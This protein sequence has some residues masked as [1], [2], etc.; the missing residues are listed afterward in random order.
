M[1]AKHKTCCFIGHRQVFLTLDDLNKLK[2]I[3]ENLILNE[4]V[5]EFYFGS[6]SKFND[7][8]HNL[9]TGLKE[10]YPKVIRKFFNCKSEYCVLE[11]EREKLEKSASFVLNKDI[12]FLGMEGEVNFNK[13][14]KTT[15]NSYIV[16][17]QAMI[18]DSDYCI[19]YYNENYVPTTKN[20]SQSRVSGTKLAYEYAVKKNKQIINVF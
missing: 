3:I 9:L 15:V 14:F 6:K 8:C 16:R 1:T 4:N 11:S 20:Q 5:L 7:I 12:K 18:D 13:K 17:N 10:K 19:F 2:S